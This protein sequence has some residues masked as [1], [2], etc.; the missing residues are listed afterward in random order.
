MTFCQGNTVFLRSK[1][2][3]FHCSTTLQFPRGSFTI[4]YR[5]VIPSSS[6]PL[7]NPEWLKAAWRMNPFLHGCS[8]PD[9]GHR[10]TNAGSGTSSTVWMGSSVAQFNSGCYQAS[11]NSLRLSDVW[12]GFKL[13]KAAKKQLLTDYVRCRCTEDQVSHA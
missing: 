7:S 11:D 9:P 13:F 8:F 5:A 4:S 1:P 6:L 12:L 2:D 10:G 3:Y